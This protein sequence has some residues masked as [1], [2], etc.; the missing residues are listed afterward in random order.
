MTLKAN[1]KNALFGMA[2]GLTLHCIAYF[3]NNNSG[4]N[5]ALRAI[6]VIS[7][8]SLVVWGCWLYIEEKGY[9]GAWGFLGLL[10]VVGCIILALFKDKKKRMA[11]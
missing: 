9:N 2:L 1:K 3:I 5:E 11:E 4:L 7:G 8:S 10:S 6:L